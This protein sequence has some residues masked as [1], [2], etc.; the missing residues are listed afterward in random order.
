VVTVKLGVRPRWGLLA[1]WG[2]LAC[3]PP[4]FAQDSGSVRGLVTSSG[5]DPVPNVAVAVVPLGLT[6]ARHDATTDELGRFE[7]TG[8]PPGHYSVSAETDALGSQIFRILVQAGGAADVH[9][10]LEAGRA[11]ATWL[12]APGNDRAAAAAFEAGVQA[13]RSGDVDQAIEHFEAALRIM[14]S[15]LD[16][17]FNIGIAYSQQEQFEAAEAAFRRALDIRAD[18][19][20]A[21]YG[22]SNL[23]SKQNRP[24]EAAD[25][26]S[27][28]NR[29]TVRSLEAG[30][31]LAL[32]RLTRGRAFLSSGNA[33]DAI[34]QFDSAV[35]ADPTLVDAHYWLG[36]AHDVTGNPSAARLSFIGYLGASPG[37][38]FAEDARRRLEALD[39]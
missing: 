29:I 14:P 18:Y 26:R 35:S 9:F 27:E 6:T 22:L 3:A 11:A 30:R 19:A 12:R 7:Q 8:L 24:D 25:A 4:V 32:E 28:A 39:R 21:Y 5:G 33:E 38:E 37:G 20:A 1:V 2:L 13:N 23:Y 10:V 36:R 17:H 16:C 34:R 31:D 15:C